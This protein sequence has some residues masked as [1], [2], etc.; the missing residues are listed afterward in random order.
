MELANLLAELLIVL[1]VAVS[2]YFEFENLQASRNTQ[3]ALK[4]L[5]E[6]REKWYSSRNRKAPARQEDVVEAVRELAQEVQQ[7]ETQNETAPGVQGP[8]VTENLNNS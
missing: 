4:K 6:S 7:N 1:L 8:E 3:A 2:V 5:F